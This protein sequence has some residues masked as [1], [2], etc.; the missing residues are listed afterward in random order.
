MPVLCIVTESAGSRRGE[1]GEVGPPRWSNNDW[2][3]I[4]GF[5]KDVVVTL[6]GQDLTFSLADFHKWFVAAFAITCYAAQGSTFDWDFAIADW[7]KMSA[8]MRY[9]SISR[10]RRF[11]QL[12]VM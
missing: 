8:Q 1:D 11:D 9:T 12:H 4:K 2:G 10:A 7:H 5:D 6:E 3:T